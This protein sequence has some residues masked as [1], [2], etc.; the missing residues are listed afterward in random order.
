MSFL[1][2]HRLNLGNQYAKGQKHTDEWKEAMRLRM[3]GNT[4]GFV[5]G[6][7]SP[8]KG[9]KSRF[10]AWNKGKKFPEQSGEN[11]WNW[12]KV[13]NNIIEKHRFRGSVE[14][15]NWRNSVFERDNYTCQNCGEKGV[16]L[17]P[18]HI[19]PLRE[20]LI[21]MYEIGNGITLCSPCHKKTFWKEK[22]F[23]KK[24]TK[25]ITR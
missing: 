14:W 8:R 1:K 24:F 25:L 11:H 5:K 15:K 10:P 21:G 16:Y 20:N 2:G 3:L 23:A 6:K 9:K 7:P 19:I 4:Q 18:H 17:E 13:R 22:E 12:K